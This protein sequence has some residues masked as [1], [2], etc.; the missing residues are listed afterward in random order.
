[1]VWPLVGREP[2][3][4]MIDSALKGHGSVVVAGP[5]GVGKSR[6]ARVAA[7]R[8]GRAV[9]QVSATEAARP[10]PL[11][12]MAA[13]LP[14]GPAGDNLLGWA[15]REILAKDPGLLLVDDAHL[16]DA[17]S[18]ALVHQLAG[19]VQ[20]VVTVRTGE[21]CADSVTALWKDRLAERI[22]LGP[23]LKTEVGE[24]L[25]QTLGAPA[26]PA[27]VD[28]LAD[29][30]QGNPLY[31][32]ELITSGALT[33]TGRWRGEV[34][35]PTR[36]IELIAARI[37]TPDQALELVAFGEPLELHALTKATGE[38]PV[39]DAEA[40]GLVRIV[41]D[42]RR[43]T[44]RLTHP[45]YGEAVRAACP[46]LRTRR[47][48][49]ELAEAIEA[50]PARRRHDVL[51]LAMWRLESGTTE[52]PEPLLAA[53]QLAWAAHDYP[54]AERLGRAALNAGAGPRAAVLL[55]PVLAF[56]GN[57]AEAERV[58]AAVW[59]QPCD[60]RT[61]ALLISTRI[62]VLSSSGRI[63]EAVRLLEEGERTLKEPDNLQEMAFW[64]ASYHLALGEFADA[65]RVADAIVAAPSGDGMLAQALMMRAWVLLFTG[66]PL[67]AVEITDR[68]LAMRERWEGAVPVIFRGLYEIRRSAAMFAGDLPGYAAA[69]EEHAALVADGHW[70][71]AGVELDLTRA[72][73]ARMRGEV[74]KAR[75]ALH[76]AEVSG[77]PGQ[78]Q[79]Q[80]WVEL[81]HASAL[82]GDANTTMEPGGAQVPPV[83]ARFNE[84]LVRPWVAAARGE[85]A[86]A[87]LAIAAADRMREYGALSQEVIAR[88][89]AVRLGAAPLVADRLAELADE[90]Q[91]WYAEAA[92]AHAA[93]WG[94]GAALL[95][96]SQRFEELG[97]AL[98]A[99]EAAAQ[100]SRAFESA[101][102]TASARSA[103]ARAW[104]L[105]ARCAGAR[106]PALSRLQAPGL[107][108]RELEIAQLAAAGLTSKEIAGRLVIS[109][110]TV[111][112]HLQM[113]YGKLGVTGRGELGGLL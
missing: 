60:E 38:A 58:L 13:L 88:H 5:A 27:T 111:E 46:S 92:A 17:T 22:D 26:D 107:T 112:N 78:Y 44:V 37:G 113:A 15:A 86:P 51:R 47:R 62:N 1:M 10:L 91:G 68:V 42:G 8:S 18:A 101:G 54:L 90:C 83:T 24:V 73:L 57:P 67:D 74:T 59:D 70:E 102:R 3:L 69:T 77:A 53:L 25:A 94:D 84:D 23:L 48:Y 36:L 9:L 98:H 81:A 63:P 55:A 61:R 16:L 103:G 82:A 2:Q 71:L 7:K 105:A 4:S 39:E 79:A 80:V 99:A 12:A 97:F 49:R 64:R 89:D 108:S 33:R 66:R 95:T 75:T 11:G 31:L 76:R 56:S 100:A 40:R 110:R 41:Q 14:A 21:P 45:L 29:L 72:V 104:T 19:R 30:S 87:E 43:T 96:A 52:D 6:L 35:L 65:L 32:R 20:L 85:G 109:I 93:A 106:T 50:T 28:R 34:E